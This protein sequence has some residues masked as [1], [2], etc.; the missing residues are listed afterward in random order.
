MGEYG[1][2]R[3]ASIKLSVFAALFSRS[4]LKPP[5]QSSSSQQS[6][7]LV[8]LHLPRPPSSL[9][10]S[11]PKTLSSFLLSPSPSLPLSRPTLLLSRSHRLF[12]TISTPIPSPPLRTLSHELCDEEFELSVSDVVAGDEVEEKTVLS[13]NERSEGTEPPGSASLPSYP[14]PK[15]SVKEKKELASYAHNLGKKLKCQQVGKAGVNP[16]VA[17]SFIETLEANELLKQA[18]H[19]LSLRCKQL[20]VHGS[21]P[22]ELNDVVKQLETATG[23]V[24]VGQIGRTVILYR[25]SLTKMKRKETQSARNGSNAK[26]TKSG[27]TQKMQKKGQVFKA[28]ARG[29]R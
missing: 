18:A 3:E 27:I 9:L 2:H 17:A 12:P 14:S 8:R 6:N 10:S 21:C 7:G 26:S 25:P 16:S 20:K 5:L 24:V 1:F 29:Q 13:D 11:L 15:L 28:S 19:Y 23:S 22:G 4:S